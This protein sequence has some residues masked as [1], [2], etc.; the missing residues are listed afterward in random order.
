MV[1]GLNK[2]SDICDAVSCPGAT[3]YILAPKSFWELIVYT[4]SD[5]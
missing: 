3:L 2:D 5:N 1:E 4:H